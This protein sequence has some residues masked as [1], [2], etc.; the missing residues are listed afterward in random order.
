MTSIK[1][2]T[3]INIYFSWTELPAYGYY[4]LKYLD[5]KL[6]KNK[7]INFRVI[8]NP[9]QFQKNRIMVDARKIIENYISEN[10][11]MMFSKSYCGF[12]T[13]AKSMLR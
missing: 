4:I 3:K 2:N 11:V 13:Q 9:N 1:K 7:L 8:S 6:K 5:S 10:K 12:C